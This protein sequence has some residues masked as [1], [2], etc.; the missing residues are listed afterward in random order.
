MNGRQ[1]ALMQEQAQ[2]D[3]ADHQNL[4]MNLAETKWKDYFDESEGLNVSDPYLK[5]VI[6]LLLE[7]TEKAIRNGADKMRIM[8]SRRGFSEEVRIANVGTFDKYVFPIIRTLIPQLAATDLVSV[9]PMSGPTSLIFFLDYLY[10]T[11]KGAVTAGTSL[12]NTI[13][14]SYSSETVTE[15]SVG[16]TSGG[17]G[18]VANFTLSFIPVVPGTVTIS[19]TGTDDAEVTDDGAGSFT[20]DYD[21][22]DIDYAT[23]AVTDLDFSGV[24]TNAQPVLATYDFNSE[25]HADTPQIDLI[26]TSSPVTARPR[27]LRARWGME[28]Q[29]DLTAIHGIDA[30]TELTSAITNEIKFEIDQ[31]IVRQLET[32]AYSPSA[33]ELPVWDKNPSTGVPYVLHKETLK[34]LFVSASTIINRRSRRAVGNW[35]V[36]GDNVA[37]IVETLS[38]FVPDTS[39]GLTRG[40]YKVGTLAGRWD[41]Y[42]DQ[43]MSA[44]TPNRFL[45]GY[46]GPTFLE[47]GYVYAPY[48]PLYTTPTIILDD[49]FSRKGLGT[50]YGKRVVNNTFYLK[51]DIDI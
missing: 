42:R 9:Q 22:G 32:I 43:G 8:D 38:N 6:A 40:V 3:A 30:E 28:A 5:S 27:K 15:E 24:T 39:A 16:V 11:T 7:N 10:G 31:E 12:F 35:I 36:A 45:M 33:S 21:A 18:T 23:G 4:G 17:D 37:D 2:R 14:K 26:I 46:K 48:V 47:A 50:R 29:Q 20:G 49:F 1:A 51:S 41:I 44:V 13:D 25:F 34:D 19:T